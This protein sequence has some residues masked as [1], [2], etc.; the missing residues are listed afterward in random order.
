MP[1][2]PVPASV[3]KK[4]QQ[5]LKNMQALNDQIYSFG[6]AKYMNAFSLL[7]EQDNDD[8]GLTI[9]LNIVEGAFWAVGSVAG[10]AGSFFASFL[11]GML[12]YWATD[13]PASINGAFSQNVL[14]FQ[15]TTEAVDSQL[16]I[17]YSNI[18]A[19][20][21]DSFTYNGVTHKLS[22]LAG[23]DFPDETSTNWKP[24]LD[25]ALFGVDKALWTALLAAHCVIT[26][27]IP[28]GDG[29]WNNEMLFTEFQDENSPPVGWAQDFY[30]QNAAYYCTWNWYTSDK[31]D[32]CT[33]DCWAVAE[34]NIGTGATVFTDGSLPADACAYI[35]ID[36]TPGEVTNPAGLFNRAALFANPSIPTA[37]YYVPNYGGGPVGRLGNVSVD[38]LRAMKNQQT[39]GQLIAREGRAEIERRIV[40]Q[41]QSDPIFAHDL[42]MRPR[43]TVE[44]FLG[45]KIPEVIAV[46]AFQELP[47]S[48]GLVIPAKN[49][50][51]PD[52]FSAGVAAQGGKSVKARA[53]AP[54]SIKDGIDRFFGAAPQTAAVAAGAGMRA[55]YQVSLSGPDGGDWILR[56]QNGKVTTEKGRVANPDVTL[57]ASGAD[58]LDMT[59]GK[60]DGVLAFFLGKLAVEGDLVLARKLRDLFP[61]ATAVS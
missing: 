16:A 34:Y 12:V 42:H 45:V 22:D 10:P 20:W 58:W 8:L 31:N 28:T 5:N 52:A 40:Q 39:L 43:M 32:C 50:S 48:F 36:S 11:S 44:K 61:H 24:M 55:V 15:A 59:T 1:A 41:A 18:D 3:T 19:H 56:V 14:R 23:F 27:Y 53:G 54:A 38:F 60:L 9:G 4:V 35:F 30:K 51:Q 37:Q 33:P 47:W 7:T 26:Q 57:R 25:S 21:N 17:Y 46:H 2:N 29:S 49:W 6:L 13:P